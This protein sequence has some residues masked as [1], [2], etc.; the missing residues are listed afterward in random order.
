[1]RPPANA[2]TGC[3]YQSEGWYS[4]TKT[5]IGWKDL[6]PVES[7]KATGADGRML[8]QSTVFD[9]EQERLKSTFHGREITG[10]GTKSFEPIIVEYRSQT[11]EGLL[12][13]QRL[14]E[15]RRATPGVYFV[16]MM[17][18]GLTADGPE[19]NHLFTSFRTND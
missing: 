5:W 13:E 6:T 2:P 9:T 12:V 19:L 8:L 18:K 16:G 15:S 1:M 3:L 11:P 14:R 4:G 10:G 7:Q 17:G